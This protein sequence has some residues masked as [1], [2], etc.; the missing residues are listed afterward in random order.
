MIYMHFIANGAFASCE[1]ATGT[2]MELSQAAKQPPELK[3]S[4]RKLRNRQT[5]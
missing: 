3:Q 1:T 4:F 2:Q 5:T